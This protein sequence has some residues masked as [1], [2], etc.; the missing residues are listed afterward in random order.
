LPHRPE[1][2]PS[3]FG[4][5]LDGFRLPAHGSVSQLPTLLGF[6]LQGFF[7]VPRQIQGFPK[8]SRS[9]AFLPNRTAWYRRFSGSRSRDQRHPPAPPPFSGGSGDHA[10]LSFR[11]SRAFIRRTFEEALSFFV[12]LALFS[13]RPPKKPENG[14]SGDSFRRLNSPLSRGT[15]PP[16]VPDRLP[17]AT[18]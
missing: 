3:G 11:T 8:T 9:Y 15:S 1:V 16:G 6:A 17:S 12:P 10:L 7:P 18:L 14:A 13:S 2:P 4:Y 5:P